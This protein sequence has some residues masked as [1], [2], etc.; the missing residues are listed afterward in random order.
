MRLFV[1]LSFLTAFTS[2]QYPAFNQASSDKLVSLTPED[3]NLYNN[4][5]NQMLSDLVRIRKEMKSLNFAPDTTFLGTN[6]Y[7]LYKIDKSRYEPIISKLKT[8]NIYVDDINTSYNG[9][10]EFRLKESM[11]ESELSHFSY[12][13]SL[14]FN[15]GPGYKPPYSGMIEVLIDS[16]INK[17][18]RY[19]Y[20]KAQVGH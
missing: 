18:W 20:Y 14:V 2:C 19:V 11:D 1:L 15:A 9:T 16:A 4:L 10:L 7:Y 3:L 8:K 12:T 6:S 13:H 5:K 17:D